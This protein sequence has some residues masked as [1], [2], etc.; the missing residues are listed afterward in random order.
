DHSCELCGKS[1]GGQP[2][3]ARRRSQGEMSRNYPAFCTMLKRQS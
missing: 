2:A 3:H 1:H